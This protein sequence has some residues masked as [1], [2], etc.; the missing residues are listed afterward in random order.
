[1]SAS[2]PSIRRSSAPAPR[3]LP[4]LGRYEALVELAAGGAGTVYLARLQGIAGFERLFAIKALHKHL[5]KQPAVVEML[6]KEARLTSQI[7]HPHVVD[8]VELGATDDGDHFLVM[9]YVEGV[10]LDDLLEHPRLDAI[11]RVRLGIAIL[12]DAMSGLD[13]AHR[14]VDATTGEPLGIVHRDVSP[15][16]ILIGMDGIG[17]VA[18]FGIASARAHSTVSQPELLR[19]TPRYMAP[20][21]VAGSTVDQRADVFALGAVLWEVITGEPLF[22]SRTSVDHILSQVLRSTIPPPS[23]RNSRIPAELDA[24]C[25]RALQRDAS[26]RFQTVAELRD[27]LA[28]VADAAR[29]IGTPSELMAELERL[30]GDRIERRREQ[31]RRAAG[32]KSGTRLRA[33]TDTQ[34]GMTPL[35]DAAADAVARASSTSVTTTQIG[36]RPLK[37]EAAAEI[38][39]TYSL[40]ELM[41]EADDDDAEAPDG[42]IGYRVPSKH[43]RRWAMLALA[44]VAIGV[45][46]LALR[47]SRPVEHGPVAPPTMS[48]P[49]TAVTA[50]ITIDPEPI[51]EPAIAAPEAVAPAAKRVRAWKPLPPP[52]PRPVAEPSNEASAPSA[53]ARPAELPLET[54]PYLLER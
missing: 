31:V 17:R 38:E 13:A 22:D 47:S 37:L 49:R 52:R 25:A 30:F 36:I 41:G 4:R 12:L 8:T 16:N 33:I 23:D 35:R 3:P 6:L 19:G 46:W 7:Q 10:S 43:W 26:E 39:R 24:V 11:N 15:A 54:N 44:V 20:E 28:N 53:P 42:G 9:A 5:A 2:S 1:M 48:A 45:S 29:L 18:D 40:D 50:P 32:R 14:A 51:I 34:L 21:Q 27:A